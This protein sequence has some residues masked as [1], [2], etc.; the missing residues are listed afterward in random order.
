MRKDGPRCEECRYHWELDETEPGR[1][2]LDDEGP[3]RPWDAA[4][5]TDHGS[6]A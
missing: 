3:T 5:D 6:A 2:A 4:D 1:R